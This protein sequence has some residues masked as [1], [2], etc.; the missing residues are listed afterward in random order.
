MA[1]VSYHMQLSGKHRADQLMKVSDSPCHVG[2]YCSV[3]N[4]KA[5]AGHASVRSH[6]NVSTWQIRHPYTTTWGDLRICRVRLQRCNQEFV[7]RLGSST[8]VLRQNVVHRPQCSNSIA[9]KPS[10]P[11]PVET[12]PEGSGSRFQ[13]DWTDASARAGPALTP[14]NL[15]P[16]TPATHEPPVAY[17]RLQRSWKKTKFDALGAFLDGRNE[18]GFTKAVRQLEEAL[19]QVSP[20]SGGVDAILA[21]CPWVT[22]NLNLPLGS[23]LVVNLCQ[24]G[25]QRVALKC[26]DWLKVCRGGTVTVTGNRK[27]QTSIIA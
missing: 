12:S 10:R 24:A 19:K 4:P 18:P 17:H 25:K 22:H 15:P 27:P 21:D 16:L 2:G 6:T 7:G 13:S 23:L 9:V 8:S 1:H 11:P 14:L 3:V 26:C 20:R 5:A